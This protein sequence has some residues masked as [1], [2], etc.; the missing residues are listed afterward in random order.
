MGGLGQGLEGWNGVTSVC[1][2]SLDYLC[3]WQVQVFVYCVKRIPAHLWC[4]QC[5]ILFHLIDICFLT[6]ICL[7]QISQI[8]TCLCEVVG[9]ELVS[10][11]SPAYMRSIAIHPAGPHG[12][13]AQKRLSC[14]HCC[15]REGS[16]QFVQG[17]PDRCDSSTS[18]RLCG[19]ETK[20]HHWY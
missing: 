18:C 4:T 7:W 20:C 10:T 12:W 19:L 9:P 1:V 3:C 2:V 17:L 6:S 8:Q 16:T 5:S 15:G 11:S 13:L 14:P